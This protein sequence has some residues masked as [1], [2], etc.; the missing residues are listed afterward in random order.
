MMAAHTGREPQR[1]A[2]VGEAESVPF[3]DEARVLVKTIEL[4]HPE[5]EGLYPD[6]YD[7][8]SQRASFRLA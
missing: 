3:F 7:V 1:G 2:A 8:I 6:E 5:T 4:S